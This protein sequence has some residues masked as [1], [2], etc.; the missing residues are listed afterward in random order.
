MTGK[1][2][3]AD[4]VG[5]IRKS[6]CRTQVHNF[7]E[8][9][10]RSTPAESNVLWRHEINLGWANDSFISRKSSVLMVARVRVNGVVMNF[11]VF[12]ARHELSRFRESARQNVERRGH[13]KKTKCNLNLLQHNGYFIY[14]KS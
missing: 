3:I 5:E 6:Y 11:T 10:A 8:I 7:T 14:P 2:R 13:S 1:L 4:D 12:A 9:T